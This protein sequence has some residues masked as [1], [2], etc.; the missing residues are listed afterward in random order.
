[1]GNSQVCSTNTYYIDK[2]PP[3]ISSGYPRKI[4]GGGNTGQTF[5][6]YI[7][8]QYYDYDSGLGV[9]T[10]T[11][12]THYDTSSHSAT[13]NY[14]GATNG[15]DEIGTWGNTLRIKSHKICDVVGNCT[16]TSGYWT[17]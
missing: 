7:A 12:L 9:R 8:Y 15:G 6:F 2:T 14:N 13:G 11:W 10:V 16:T 17:R 5:T 1:M 4:N 3:T